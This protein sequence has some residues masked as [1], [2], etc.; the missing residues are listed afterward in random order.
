MTSVASSNQNPF[1]QTTQAPMSTGSRHVGKP[2]R[3][4]HL[5]VSHNSSA[6]V[7]SM[8]GS[9]DNTKDSPDE[10]NHL[11]HMKDKLH[12][13]QSNKMLLEQK[14]VEYESKLK[15]ISQEKTT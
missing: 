6:G 7:R 15:S 9:V 14:I 5:T 10:S 8:R 2:T 1:I 4:G 3:H 11:I 13:I 12:Q